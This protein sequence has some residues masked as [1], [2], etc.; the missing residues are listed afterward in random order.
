MDNNL[1]KKIV[2]IISLPVLFLAV[3]SSVSASPEIQH[4]KTSKGARVYFVPSNDIPMVDLRIV[5]D[6]GSARDEKIPGAAVMA[7]GLLAEGA[8]G[9]SAQVL[10]EK[11]EEVG[12]QFGNGS[13][14]DMAWL[15]LRSLRDDKYLRPALSNL[16]NILIKPDFP[17][18]AFQRELERLKISVKAKKQS[19]NA[20]A[21]DRFF[22]EMYGNHPYASPSTGTQESLKKLNLRYLKAFYKKYYVASNA[23][24]SIV[25]QLSRA[26]AE[27]L[28]ND[29]LAKLPAGSAPQELPE[30]LPLKQAKTIHID[31]PSVQS[32]VMMGQVGVAR[33]DA[34]Y[35]SL[36][37]AN[38]AFGGSG[39]G[40]RLMEEVREK[41]GLAYSAYSYFSPMHQAGPFQIG[42][43]TRNDQVDEALKIIRL[44]LDKYVT[45]GPGEDELQDSLK[46]ITG[47]FPLRIDSNKKITEYL[48]VIGFYDLP[49]DYLNTFVGNINKQN[50]VKV[51]DALKRR[52]EPQKMLTV[53]VGA[54]KN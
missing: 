11:F 32:T 37:L 54:K 31:F 23:V 16:Q 46:N 40:S 18:A 35:F 34:D 3:A 6:A 1:M 42:L 8:A 29:L 45:Q 53:I 19:P 39:F 27:E 5:F 12:A 38:H 41:R 21:S 9:D 2:K 33:G 50:T 51:K 20:I 13:L 36:Y 47:G 4:W 22:A 25:G 43:Q 49:L 15:S 44:E 10:A 26:E 52:I 30:V 48:S 28:V 17:G 7:N 14:K 24:V